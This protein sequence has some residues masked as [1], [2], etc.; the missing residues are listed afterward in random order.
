MSK[1]FDKYQKRRL[2]SSYFSVVLSI[3]LVLFMVGFLGLV[4]LK[5]TSI[6]NRVKEKTA[7]TLFLKDN[8][9]KKNIDDLKASLDKN[10]DVTGWLHRTA[11]PSIN[12]TFMPGANYAAGWE[13]GQGMNNNPFEIANTRYENAKAEPY[14]RIGWLRS[15]YSIFHSFST[16]CFMDELAVQRGVDPLQNQLE[17][18]GAD[19]ILPFDESFEF[20][21]SR[22]KN[23]LTR[24]AKNAGWGKKLPKGHG[25]G[26]AVQYSF[27]S[28]IAQVIEV[29]VI[30]NKLKVHNINTCIDCG[31][32]LIH[33]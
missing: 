5:S 26:L 4:L 14:V 27:Y 7:M 16:N 23:V 12:S 22:L 19:R 13:I 1:S 21:T 32:S 18:I 15:V 31:L 11:F 29:S 20:K 24:A 6:A 28:Y 3:S 33:I 17:M 9:T 8:V 30:D 25:M 10:G 2:R